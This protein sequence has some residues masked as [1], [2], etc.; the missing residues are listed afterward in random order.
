MLE[1]RVFGF[2]SGVEIAAVWQQLSFKSRKETFTGSVIIA[3]AF[4]RHGLSK[5]VFGK[6]LSQFSAGVLAAS[7]GMKYG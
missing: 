1:D 2:I 3:V 5:G 4:G 6:L 7:I